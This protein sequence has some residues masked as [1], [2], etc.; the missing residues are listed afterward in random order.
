MKTFILSLVLATMSAITADAQPI[1]QEVPLYPSDPP[2]PHLLDLDKQTIAI[3]KDVHNSGAIL[4]ND[5]NYAAC[6]YMYIGSLATIEPI[7]K[8]HPKIQQTIS[9]GRKSVENMAVDGIQ[10]QAFKMHEVIEKVRTQLQT[11]VKKMEKAAPGEL[12]PTPEKKTEPS[13]SKGEMTEKQDADMAAAKKEKAMKEAEKE[14]AM[15]EK[16]MAE[17][18]RAEELAEK[19]KRQQEK[20]AKAAEK[21]AGGSV[22]FDGKPVSK[23]EI[24]MTS[25]NLDEPRVF[26]ATTDDA[27]KFTLPKDVVDG[28][29]RI[30]ISGDKVPSQYAMTNSSPLTVTIKNGAGNF[31]W[32]LEK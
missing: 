18:K 21:N 14:K 32:K 7:L 10:V 23:A 28:E 3:L 22:M 8:H 16:A 20:A 4:Y 15:A 1:E 26:T 5:N 29:Y 30:T 17:K 2:A 27:G 6:Y 11:E 25:L 24:A 12:N 31:D 19:E 13:T 9:Q